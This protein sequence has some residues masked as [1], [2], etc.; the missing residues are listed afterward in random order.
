MAS[1]KSISNKKNLKQPQQQKAAAPKQQPKSNFL[2]W[3]FKAL[4][5]QNILAAIVVVFV[6]YTVADENDGYKWVK[7]SLLK[8]NWEIVKKY[9]KAALN[10]RLQMKLGFDY[11]FLNYIKE[12]TPDTAII[13]FPIREQILEKGGNMQLT[14]N[15]ASKFWVT[16]FVYPR[17]ILYME[18][19]A[20]NPLYKNVTHVAI[21]AMHGYE[22]LEYEMPQRAWFDVLPKKS[23]T[24]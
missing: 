17:R 12:H 15:I 1:N 6:L 7:E 2:Q 5:W 10:E 9:P 4:G 13:L 8:S 22:E 19:K 11:A 20:A 16:H 21:C 24:K 3:L 18:E 23:E 14:S